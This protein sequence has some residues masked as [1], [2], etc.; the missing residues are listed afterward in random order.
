MSILLFRIFI[1]ISPLGINHSLPVF[2][3]NYFNGLLRSRI[4]AFIDRSN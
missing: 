1:E 4:E 3:Q 2:Q